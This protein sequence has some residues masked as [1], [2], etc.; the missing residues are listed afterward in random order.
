MTVCINSDVFDSVELLEALDILLG[1]NDKRALNTS[2]LDN[3]ALRTRIER[4]AK[5]KLVQK[6]HSNAKG[7]TG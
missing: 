3:A 7:N 4:T 5:R 1:Q 2:E 6:G